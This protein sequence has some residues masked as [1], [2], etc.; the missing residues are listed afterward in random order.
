MTQ[1][2]MGGAAG[3]FIVH[4]ESPQKC[5][6]YGHV[7]APA[8]G[9]GD[10]HVVADVVAYPLKASNVLAKAG[11]EASVVAFII[12]GEPIDLADGIAS[13]GVPYYTILSKFDGVVL[14]QDALPA[15]DCQATQGTFTKADI[16]TA[17]T[18]LNGKF[19]EEP[20]NQSTQTS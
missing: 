6:T 11:E 2:T 3:D 19:V 18:A 12:A 16:V 14:N 5:L 9:N 8:S 17:I 13:S 20:D 7:T 15:K 1:K 10:G 4:M